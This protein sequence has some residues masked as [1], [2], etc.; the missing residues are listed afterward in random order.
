MEEI[1]SAGIHWRLI[2]FALF[3]GLLVYF[4]KNPLKEFWKTRSQKI[5]SDLEESERLRRDAEKQYRQLEARLADIENEVQTLIRSLE[6]EGDLEKKRLI[7]DTEKIATRIKQDAE[8]IADQEVR[9]ARETLKAQAIQLSVEMAER[10][11]RDN[12]KDTDQQ[13]LVGRYLEKL[14]KENGRRVSS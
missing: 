3:V 13:K 2:N 12:F 11:I 6:E 8:R 14:E 5:Q 7:E 1:L 9:R 4:L 10:L